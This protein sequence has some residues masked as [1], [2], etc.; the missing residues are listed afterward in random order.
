MGFDMLEQRPKLHDGDKEN[1]LGGC[2]YPELK[3]IPQRFVQ[4]NSCFSAQ[5][6]ILQKNIS[7]YFCALNS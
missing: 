2:S 6:D 7:Q 3:E 4:R 5:E 1:N